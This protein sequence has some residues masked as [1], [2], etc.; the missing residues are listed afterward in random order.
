MKLKKWVKV[1]LATILLLVNIIIYT[2]LGNSNDTFEM[3]GW[4]IIIIN[5]LTLSTIE[6]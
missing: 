2:N 6:V 3:I 5:F 1:L 4:I